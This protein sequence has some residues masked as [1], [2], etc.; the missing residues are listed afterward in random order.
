MNDRLEK[1][2]E[3]V[4]KEM[5][6][7]DE[8]EETKSTTEEKP[9]KAT[10]KK[11]VKKKTTAVKKT[12]AKKVAKPEVDD[13]SVKLKDIAKELKINARDARKILRKEKVKNP[14][15]WSWP[16]KSAD[17]KKVRDLLSKAK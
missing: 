8:A 6:Q 14:G 2:I 10:A 16:D 12:T 7:T 11:V 3:E 17:L 9:V 15:R 5:N 13:N 4:K 1:A